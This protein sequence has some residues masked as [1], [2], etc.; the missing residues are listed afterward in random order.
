MDRPDI[1]WYARRLAGLEGYAIRDFLIHTRVPDLLHYIEQLETE[2]ND[3]DNVH[4]V[5]GIQET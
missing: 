4:Q 2:L 1:N 5:Q 3:R